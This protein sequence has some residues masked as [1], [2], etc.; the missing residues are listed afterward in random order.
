[1]I[2]KIYQCV[3]LVC[4]TS[5]LLYEILKQEI[6]ILY[7]KYH[8]SLQLISFLSERRSYDLFVSLEE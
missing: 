2:L 5:Y 4:V 8:C 1:L 6:I 7:I 3:F